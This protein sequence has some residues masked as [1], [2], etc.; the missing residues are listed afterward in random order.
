MHSPSLS[1]VEFV[2]SPIRKA[3]SL[4]GKQLF[5]L[6]NLR[7]AKLDDFFLDI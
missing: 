7:S 4:K 5:L 1:K 6:L 3:A 2:F